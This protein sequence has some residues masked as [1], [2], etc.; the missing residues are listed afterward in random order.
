MP[1]SLPLFFLFLHLASQ[2][3]NVYGK[4]LIVL[5]VA[6]S[7]RHWKT[8]SQLLN[9]ESSSIIVH[10][11]LS[12]LLRQSNVVSL[13]ER[14]SLSI[15][16][17]RALFTLLDS[18]L[19]HFASH[20]AFCFSFSSDTRVIQL[21][22]LLCATGMTPVHRSNFSPYHGEF[23]F[24]SFSLSSS[25]QLISTLC[26]FSSPKCVSLF[27]VPTSALSSLCFL[28]VNLHS[29]QLCILSFAL[30]DNEAMSRS[31]QINRKTLE[32]LHW[33]E[34]ETHFVSSSPVR[35]PSSTSSRVSLRSFMST[36][37][38]ISLCHKG[39]LVTL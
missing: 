8:Q 22:T 9:S 17:A 20:S 27:L 6:S 21:F 28:F 18:T 2:F 38:K 36:R 1:L 23:F 19:F 5:T 7:P 12:S 11:V 25:T 4:W 24:L 33:W 10:H 16:L 37:L 15:S 3:V 14:F 26:L 32:P 30:S 31:V 29:G 35:P 39:D 13:S 34:W